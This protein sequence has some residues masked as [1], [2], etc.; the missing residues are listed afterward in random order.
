MNTKEKFMKEIE[1]RNGLIRDLY[2]KIAELR[3]RIEE[4]E[5]VH[6]TYSSRLVQE[7]K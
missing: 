3:R 5:K 2:Q 4:L 6:A 7:L 1:Y